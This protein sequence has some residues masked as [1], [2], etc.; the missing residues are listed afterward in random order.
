MFRAS[1]LPI[2]RSYQLYT[3]QM[4]CFTQVMWP[5]PRTVRLELQFQPNFGYLMHLVAYLYEDYH[6]ALSLEHKV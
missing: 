1:S 3:W 5:L 6:D 4:I 2:I